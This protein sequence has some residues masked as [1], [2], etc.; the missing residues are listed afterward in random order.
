ML[1][2]TTL[3]K[4]KVE[5]NTIDDMLE[6]EQ[7]SQFRNAYLNSVSNSERRLILNAE[8]IWGKYC[9]TPLAVPRIY[10]K[11]IYD[12]FMTNKRPVTKIRPDIAGNTYGESNFESIDLFDTNLAD[13]VWTTNPYPNFTTE[14]KDFYNQLMDLLPFKKI[15]ACSFWSSTQLISPHRDQTVFLDLPLSFRV[16]LYDNN[17]QETLWVKECLPG[18]FSFDQPEDK[19]VLPR[20]ADTNSFAWNNLRVIHGSD[21]VPEYFKILLIVNF[22]DI[23]WFKYYKLLERSVD[24][25]QEHALISSYSKENFLS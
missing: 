24:L 23:D 14:F 18:K 10:D 3:R 20:L 6:Q 21:R 25:Y 4:S 7:F 11:K 2:E 19:F 12:W 16:M 17:P 5:K 22:A 13:A 1:A 15:T 9:F 8:N